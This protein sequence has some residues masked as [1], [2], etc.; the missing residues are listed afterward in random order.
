MGT[1][2]INQLPE[3]SGSLTNDDIF[4]FMDDPT[5]NSITKKISLNKIV[6]TNDPPVDNITYGRKNRTWV[7]MTSPANLQIRRGTL[8]EVNSI[9][10]LEGEPL[11][12]TDS[13]ILRV[14][15]GITQGGVPISFSESISTPTATITGSTPIYSRNAVLITL[16]KN[17]MTI[18][19]NVT[20][21]TGPWVEGSWP[22][23]NN[24]DFVDGRIVTISSNIEGLTGNL[25]SNMG[26]VTNLTSISLNNLKYINGNFLDSTTINSLT[27]LS[28]PE[29]VNITGN[30]GGLTA[31]ALTS[32]QMPN[33]T[34]LKYLFLTCSNLTSINL[35]LLTNIDY[36]N[37]T[38]NSLISL[39]LP[40]LK[41]IV[42]ST[43]GNF[44]I[45]SSSIT[46]ISIPSIIAVGSAFSNTLTFTT[47]ALQTLTLPSLGTWKNCGLNVS[48]TNAS[49]N[50][51]SV[52][53]LL[54]TFAYMD[55]TNGT[56]SYGSPRSINISGGSSASPSNLGSV[57][58]NGSNFVC[59]GTTCT[60]NLTSHGYS[61]GDVLRV[62]GIT[63]ATNANRYAVITV[64]NSN[65]FTYTISSQ[66]ATGAGTATII[67]AGPNA[68]AL[69]T[70]GVT[71]TTN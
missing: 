57:T 70:R 49:L 51:S 9:T 23:Y 32:F 14:G 18:N 71:L 30:F 10:P 29:V 21:G 16:P 7:N 40:S 27:T 11:W 65:Q 34:Y 19:G 47:P 53:D 52:D 24:Q 26:T 68:K 56:T 63:T 60:V 6:E 8:S 58:T 12:A 20:T 35:P 17:I 22:P 33:L 69:V 66:T 31:N 28:L 42:T 4:I 2:R 44:N 5:G 62:S 36:F 45:S 46:S 41:Y 50:Q 15:D 39:S 37:L 3:G 25:F 48:I 43:G 61:N 67:K 55:G 1:F 38:V 59:S 13:K 54:A 64:T